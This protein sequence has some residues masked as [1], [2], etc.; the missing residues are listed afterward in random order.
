MDDRTT[1]Y[2]TPRSRLRARRCARQGALTKPDLY[3]KL[4]GALDEAE[5][6]HGTQGNAIFCLAI[7]DRLFVTVVEQLGRAKLTDQNE[8]Q[9]GKPR[10]WRRV[11]IEKPFGHSLDSARELN[12][13][14]LRTLREPDLQDRPISGKAHGPEHS[15]VPFRQRAVRADPESRSDRSRADHRGRDGGRGAARQFYESAGALRDMVPNHMFSLFSIL[16]MQP[17]AGFDAAAIRSRKAEVLAAMPAVTSAQVVRGQY[18]AGTVLGKEVKAYR[19]EP[20]LCSLMS[21]PVLCYGEKTE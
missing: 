14:I 15:G 10:F 21:V 4:G 5:K 18:G 12:A 7:A 16:A 2:Q 19:R 13:Q 3:D 17:P 9:D 8:D 11:E 20:K 6:V 1:G